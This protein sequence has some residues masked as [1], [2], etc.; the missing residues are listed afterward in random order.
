M[1]APRTPSNSER[2]VWGKRPVFA[3][4]STGHAEYGRTL[5]VALHDADTRELRGV[6]PY[7]LFTWATPRA[8]RRDLGTAL[9]VAGRA[10]RVE[11]AL[12]DA[13]E[14]GH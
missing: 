2:R 1:A 7:P 9:D 14:P 10:N 8:F 6:V 12:Q 5:E 11:I 13:P 3:A 4:V